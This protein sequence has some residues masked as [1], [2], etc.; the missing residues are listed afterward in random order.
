[1]NSPRSGG[2]GDG[3]CNAADLDL[4]SDALINSESNKL[5]ERVLAGALMLPYPSKTYCAGT[6]DA[7]AEFASSFTRLT[8]F[9]PPGTVLTNSP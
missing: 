4:K 9:A 5:H 3:R 8:S 6:V 7:D 1:M 2:R